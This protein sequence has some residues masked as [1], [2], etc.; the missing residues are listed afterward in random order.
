MER[1]V[2]RLLTWTISAG[3][4][5]RF[6]T[7]NVFVVS[8]YLVTTPPSSKGPTGGNGTTANSPETWATVLLSFL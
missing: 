4:L 1:R 5:D 8:R 6:Y 7:G 2:L 3:V